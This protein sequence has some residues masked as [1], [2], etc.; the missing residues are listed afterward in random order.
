MQDL[1]KAIR[2]LLAE[3]ISLDIKPG[4]VILTGR[5]KNK[6]RV[7][8]TIGTDKYGQPTV[9]GKSILKF[10][11]EK[12]MSK[13]HWS[14]KS[15][16]ELKEVRKL[17][18][19]IILEYKK[20]N[21]DDCPHETVF[22]Q[23]R[24][25]KIFGE[26]MPQIEWDQFAEDVNIE[27]EYEN[28]REDFEPIYYTEFDDWFLRSLAP[29]TLQRCKT[30]AEGY[31]IVSPC[32]G[33]IRQEVPSGAISLKKSVVHL[34][35]LLGILNVPSILQISLRKTDYH[36]IHAPCD[37]IISSIEVFNQGE[38]F[39]ESEA[40]TIIDIMCVEGTVTLMLIGEWTVQTF[41]TNVSVGQSVSKLEE[42]G[43]FY[44][45]SQVILGYSGFS[46]M[47]VEPDDKTRVFPG[48]PLFGEQQ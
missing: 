10:K 26:K 36:R 37:G 9:N 42:L 28:P 24:G 20:Y 11:I 1:R 38:L 35:T 13:K 39:K 34:D 46:K 25:A 6:R 41:V 12:K 43:Y 2:R 29:E 33:T 8:K 18:R 48:I 7:V 23:V 21:Q 15:R 30:N 45:G 14:A 31:P 16:A 4:D 27:K 22:Q 44:F 47:L 3:A 19:D 40:C 17:V 32:Q 5:F